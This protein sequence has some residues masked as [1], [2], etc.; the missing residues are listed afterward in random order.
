MISQNIIDRIT[1]EMSLCY[2][3]IGRKAPDSVSM[4]AVSIA[5]AISF[6]DEEQ[7][8]ETFKRAKDIEPIPSQRTLKE[9][10]KNFG[11]EVM[12][13]DAHQA[14]DLTSIEYSDPRSAW[15]PKEDVKKRVNL[16]NAIKNY[17]DAVGG[18]M[19]YEYIQ[20]HKCTV[21]KHGDRKVV[22][23]KNPDAVAAFDNPIK[24]YLLYLYKKYLTHTQ[25]YKGFPEGALLNLGM[26]PPT[27]E[28]L[29][30][31]LKAEGVIK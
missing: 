4:V 16:M 24:D 31:M 2:E 8:H 6:S 26:T 15:L 1:E 13:Y 29:K 10:F 25:Q 23:W 14:D 17:C 27:I 9:C 20:T 19:A 21:E 11:E 5:D 18:R 12:K 30:I 3:S 7:V 28:D 22:K